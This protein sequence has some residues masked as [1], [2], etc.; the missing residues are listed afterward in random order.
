MMMI[1]MIVIVVVV[2]ITMIIIMIRIEHEHND[3]SNND[4]YNNDNSNEIVIMMKIE[5]IDYTHQPQLRLYPNARSAWTTKTSG[6]RSS[7]PPRGR[8][9]G[10]WHDDWNMWNWSSWGGN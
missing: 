6:R 3:N 8:S 1:T 2:V 10:A 9:H 4:N 5:M 7:K